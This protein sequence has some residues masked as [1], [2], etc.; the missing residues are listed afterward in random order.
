MT[1]IFLFPGQSSIRRDIFGTARAGCVFVPVNP[2][3]KP[4]QVEHILRDCNARVLVTSPE[5]FAVLAQTLPNCPD[6]RHVVLTG[7]SAATAAHTSIN[8]ASWKSLLEAGHPARSH[9]VIDSAGRQVW[10]QMF[11]RGTQIARQHRLGRILT[12]ERSGRAEGLVIPRVD[13]IPAE[14]V[15]QVG[16]AD[17]VHPLGVGVD[18]AVGLDVLVELAARRHE[19]DD[20][21]AGDL[22]DPVAELHFQPGCFGVEDDLPH[23]P[24]VQLSR[25][26]RLSAPPRSV[27]AGLRQDTGA[28]GG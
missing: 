3:L 8:V 28:S 21:D 12:S 23:A 27:A 26:R 18:G 2:L 15:L 1:S 5:W 24:V 14:L 17:A 9:R 11:K 16:G 22:D 6:L 4:P 20:L 19:V 10:I 13:G 25:G 7:D